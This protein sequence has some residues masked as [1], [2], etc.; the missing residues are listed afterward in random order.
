MIHRLRPAVLLFVVAAWLVAGSAPTRA[1]VSLPTSVA[2][3]PTEQG[4]IFSPGVR[5]TENLPRPYVEEEFIVQGR[6]TIHIYAHDPPHGPADTKPLIPNLPYTTRIIVRRPADPAAFKGTVVVEWWNSTAGFDTAPVWD[7]SAEFFARSGYVYVGF[8]NAKNTIDFLVAGCPRL[9]FLAPECGTRYAGLGI[10]DNGMAY[11]I[12][13]AI[14]KLL[15]SDSD[16]NPLPAEY[17]VE[18]VFHAGESQQAGS[19]I[20]FASAFHADHNDGYFVQSGINARK[21]SGFSHIDLAQAD[22]RVRTD[23]PVPVYQLIT[24]TD[25]EVLGFG[26]AARQTDTSTY[27][28]YEVPGGSHSTVHK[29]IEVLPA[30]LFT[31]DAVFLED[32]CGFPLNTTADGPVF[33]SHVLNALWAAMDRQARRGVP[34]PSGRQ[35]D[36]IGDELVFDVLGNPTGGVRVPAVE[37]PLAK[38]ISGNVAA[39]SLPQFLAFIGRLA[40]GLSG[41]VEAFDE[42]TLDSL[43]PSHHRYVR[44]VLRAVHKLWRDRLLLPHD[45]WAIAWEAL[46]SD[47]GERRPR[48][49]RWRRHRD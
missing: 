5:L 2:P 17:Q 29:D 24:Q 43:Y 44:D 33:V 26:T 15:K 42:E 45:A 19:I 4:P 20:T 22:R 48:H 21:I 49:W 46:I 7:P 34:P 11:D 12:G 16:Q 41:S 8:T 6:A 35:M 13:N 40:C 3:S 9:G 23:L 32:L 47:V 28:Y 25:F 39:E 1:E 31:Q 10:Y 38:Y 36:T 30:G 18:R 27:R 37:V 14:A